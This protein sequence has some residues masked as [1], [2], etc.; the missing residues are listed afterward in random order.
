M[1]SETSLLKRVIQIIALISLMGGLIY[2]LFGR[3]F[4]GAL[5]TKPIC[6]D[7]N[8]ILIS[9]DTLSANHLPCYGY[10]RNTAPY[11]CAFAKENILFKNMFSNSNTTL[12]SHVSLL[13]GLYPSK[14][15][16][17]VPN[18][19]ILSSQIAFLPEVLKRNGY[20][21]HFYFTLADSANLPID[22]VFNRGIDT[23]TTVTHPN[24]W[25]QGLDILDSNNAQGKKTFLFL[26]TYWVHSPYIVENKQKQ[27]FGNTMNTDTIPD[28]W[29]SL[30]ECTSEFIT[31]LTQAIQEDVENG[32]WGDRDRDIYTNLYAELLTTQRNNGIG[33]EVIC[34]NP[35]Y[36]PVLSLYVRTYYS[37]LLSSIDPTQAAS[38]GDLYD[39]KIRELDDYL[40]EVI[41]HVT[42]SNLKKNTLIVITSDHG[43][44]FLEHGQWEHGKNLYD[45]SIK[46]PL[47]VYIPGYGNKTISDLAQS[48][49]IMPT[50]L[51]LVGIPNIDAIDG[52]DLF[53]NEGFW[54]GDKYTVS[55]K[56][57]DNM[58]TIRDIRWKLFLNTKT[59]EN[60]P[61]ELY[62]GNNDPAEMD[63][64][65]LSHPNI[66]QRLMKQ[67]SKIEKK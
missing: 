31:Y 57:I 54:H 42:S 67:L 59:G 66:V 43:E 6:K 1:K 19:D 7:C 9:L 51:R 65:I 37:Y 36:T 34:D 62:D 49:D 22:T 40:Q 2:F 47:I 12:P 8:I 45:T 60:I 21:T 5:Q 61:Y 55:E 53:K 50:L 25:K 29:T 64:V 28:T 10:K 63:N 48:I 32:Y 13:T 41:K 58:K 3:I 38:V 52:R 15:N 11:L 16:V 23:I 20:N 46:V 56:V 4:L 44:E 26:H 35:R 14:H 30:T 27:A 33:R 39:S 24:D 18:R 17:N